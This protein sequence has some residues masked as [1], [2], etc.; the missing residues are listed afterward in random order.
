MLHATRVSSCV[1]L[2]AGG[3]EANLAHSAGSVSRSVWCIRPRDSEMNFYFTCV[4]LH[5]ASSYVMSSRHCHAARVS[6][7]QSPHCSEA[8]EKKINVLILASGGLRPVD[9]LP[10]IS[11]FAPPSLTCLLYWTEAL[12]DVSDVDHLVILFVSLTEAD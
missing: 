1:V 7:Y 5:S 2:D 12:S 8:K 4:Q 9:W 3:T 6:L 11:L 10:I